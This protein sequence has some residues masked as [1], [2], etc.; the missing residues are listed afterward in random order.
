MDLLALTLADNR[1]AWQLHADGHY[2]QQRPAEGEAPI[3]L[4]DILMQQALEKYR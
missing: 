1:L 4:H 3:A 2:E